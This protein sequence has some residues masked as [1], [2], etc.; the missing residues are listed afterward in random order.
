MFGFATAI[1][2][3]V[4]L[5]A[6]PA[7]DR[8]SKRLHRCFTATNGRHVSDHEMFSFSVSPAEHGLSRALHPTSAGRAPDRRRPQT[9]TLGVSGRKKGAAV[10]LSDRGELKQSPSWRRVAPSMDGGGS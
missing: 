1:P 3:V 10:K 2:T 7:Y 5:L 9:T 8:T 4:V 6:F